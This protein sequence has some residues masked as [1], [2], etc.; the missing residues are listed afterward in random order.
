MNI[1]QRLVEECIHHKDLTQE[2][3]MCQQLARVEDSLRVGQGDRPLPQKRID[4]FYDEV[5]LPENQGDSLKAVSIWLRI[6][7]AW[8]RVKGTANVQELIDR[9]LQVLDTERVK[10]SEQEGC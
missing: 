3:H 10:D 5:L 6:D 2:C 9:V 8:Y 1:H 4:I 7:D